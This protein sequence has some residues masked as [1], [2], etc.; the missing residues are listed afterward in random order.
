ML[1]VYVFCIGLRDERK[2]SSVEELKTQIMR[3]VDRANSYFERAR[4]EAH[5]GSDIKLN[6]E[7]K[8]GTS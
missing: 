1:C 7:Y 6:N 4:H 2:F 3:D 8:S 5:A